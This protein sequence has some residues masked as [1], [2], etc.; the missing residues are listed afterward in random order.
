MIRPGRFLRQISRHM[1][2]EKRLSVGSF[3]VL[4]IVLILVDIF[5]IA[6][7]SI[8][9]EYQRMLNTVRMEVF[10]IDAVPDSTL[11]VVKEA[12]VTIDGVAAVDF[13]SK[14]EAARILESE[15][16]PGILE[17]L[18]ENPL[19]RSFI[20]SFDR[21]FRLEELDA[22]ERRIM[23][24]SGVDM[25]EFGRP[26]IEKVEYVGKL[27]RRIGYVVGGIILFV[28]ML[29]MA[30]T[31]RLTAR[32]K[33]RDFFQLKLLGAGPSYLLYPFLAEGFL[34]ACIAAALGWILLHYIS[35]QVSFTAITLALPSVRDIAVYSFLAG[36][37]GII[38]AYLGIR[39]LLIS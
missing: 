14:D 13:I 15:L 31:N 28:V 22:M 36:V 10:L 29:T 5:W 30:N 12:L 3:L 21:L 25:V 16:G 33:S 24:L 23:R 2:R 9:G 7:I 38:G 35:D 6:S 18:D 20:L 26:W 17:G 32:S 27:L 39:R 34:S 19:P 11:N 1:R 37:T 4:A 8:T